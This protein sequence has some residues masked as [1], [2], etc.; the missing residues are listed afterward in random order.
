[1]PDLIALQEVDHLE[2]FQESLHRLGCAQYSTS[3]NAAKMVPELL[4]YI[5]CSQTG[6]GLHIPVMNHEPHAILPIMHHK[7]DLKWDYYMDLMN[8]CRPQMCCYFIYRCNVTI[9][10]KLN[11]T[12]AVTF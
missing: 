1:M 12:H 6:S 9:I 3:S 10:N 4:N 2:A 8:L 11:S 7:Q 5:V